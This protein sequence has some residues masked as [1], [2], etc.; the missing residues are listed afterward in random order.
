LAKQVF[1]KYDFLRA[2]HGTSRPLAAIL[3]TDLADCSGPMSS[4]E[5]RNHAYLALSLRWLELRF[6]RLLDAQEGRAR[7]PEVRRE[8]T[9]VAASRAA[10]ARSA[11]PPALAALARRLDLSSFERDTVLLA[12]A[13]DLD[14]RFSSLT[15]Q[16]SGSA[17]PTPGFA[18]QLLARGRFLAFAPDSALRRER[19]IELLPRPGQSLFA[20]PM[21]AGPGI[22]VLIKGR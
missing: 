4:E 17:S 11:P 15:R 1:E 21:R 8:L 20:S 18:L 3:A 12:A 2:D 5:E 16:C 22:D 19:L 14:P 6:R 9:S 10:A 13:A 7:P